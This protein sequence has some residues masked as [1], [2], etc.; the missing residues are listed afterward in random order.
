MRHSRVHFAQHLITLAVREF[1][2][3]PEHNLYITFIIKMSLDIESDN[4][5]TSSETDGQSG[6][7]GE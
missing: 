7:A 1:V 2:K 3:E 6:G 5:H 4:S